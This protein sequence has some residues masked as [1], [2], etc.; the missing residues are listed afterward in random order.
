MS[1]GA[2][3]LGS[4]MTMK[5]HFGHL[6]TYIVMSIMVEEVKK[7]LEISYTTGSPPMMR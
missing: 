6:V 7:E 3:R 4:I 5:S 2:R 1:I